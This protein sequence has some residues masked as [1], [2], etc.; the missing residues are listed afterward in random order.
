MELKEGQNQGRNERTQEDYLKSS[1]K[2]HSKCQVVFLLSFIS[3]LFLS[4]F[5]LQPQLK[6]S[7]KQTFSLGSVLSRGFSKSPS[8]Y[9]VNAFIVLQTNTYGSREEPALRESD[10]RCSAGVER[11][12]N[13]RSKI[14][15][16][17]LHM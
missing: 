7:F 8:K 15:P 3:A 14:S 5:Q 12:E 11:V 16:P 10:E 4:F 13:A 1:A 17:Q 6:R 9:E 2:I